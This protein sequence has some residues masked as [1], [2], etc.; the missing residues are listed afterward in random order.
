MALSFGMD[1]AMICKACKT[2]N[3]A[4][5]RFCGNCGTELDLA[6]PEA[7]APS[8]L[9]RER[10][11]RRRLVVLFADVVSSTEI[12]SR[13]D[14]E[15]WHELL[16]DYQTVVTTAVE[17]L[18]GYVAK[19]LGDGVLA[20]FGWPVGHE[21][22]GERAALAGRA[23]LDGV[24]RLNRRSGLRRMPKIEIR[25]GI[26]V[27]EVVVDPGGEVYGDVPSIAARVQ[28]EAPVDNVVVTDAVFRS[29]AG[30]L[31]TEALGTRVLRGVD[32]PLRLHRVLSARL[33]P[34][35]ATGAETPFVG[36]SAE[37]RSIVQAW[38][39][40]YAGTGRVVTVTGEAGIG[41][42]RLVREFRARTVGTPHLWLESAGSEIF[43]STPFY[44]VTRLLNRLVGSRDL[45]PS[46][47]KR[48]L[49][50]LLEAAGLDVAESLA[51][52]TE[53]LTGEPAE[54]DAAAALE[55]TARRAL[56]LKLL[57]AWIL[58]SA[59][60]RPTVLVVEDLHWVDPS[61]LEVLEALVDSPAAPLLVILTAR[62]EFRAPW[63]VHSHHSHII[64]G[65]LDRSDIREI[66]KGAA[67]A[68]AL[69]EYVVDSI[70]NRTSGI[71]LF[72]EELARLVETRGNGGS[73][74]AIPE[75]LASSLTARLD[76]LGP[77]RD[78]AQIGAVIGDE[79]DPALLAVVSNRTPEALAPLLD[80]M[81]ETGILA[82]RTAVAGRVLAFRH[83][84]FRDAAYGSLLR[85]R[86]RQLHERVADAIAADF[87]A[88]AREH[89]SLPRGE[90]PTG[91]PRAPIGKLFPS[92]KSC[93]SP[94]SATPRTSTSAT[95]WSAFCR[96]PRDIRRPRPRKPRRRRANCPKRSVT[97]SNRCRRRR[98]P[99]P[100]FRARGNMRRPARLP[101]ASSN[102]RAATAATSPWPV[103]AWCR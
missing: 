22:D 83:S 43:R 86:R 19:Y 79:F 96:S 58:Q 8:G 15:D 97:P 49:V 85:T 61:T 94:V 72:A 27:G 24:V 40:A 71:P 48:R 75:T 21:N 4:G 88:M 17:G 35:P 45:D 18:G 34:E 69:L 63:P 31:A 73:S 55:P 6:R 12:S 11:E 82:S 51:P 39:V 38:D 50:H 44:A 5:N 80:R 46:S 57:V 87:P 100:P 77:A 78:I 89:P 2:D 23:I 25:I 9:D 93:R 68:P 1:G 74:Q 36:R 37:L 70:A 60:L 103:P 90:P 56:W 10:G 47:R 98:P 52:L 33:V 13:L 84:L 91:K 20:Y 81:A 7:A 59:K 65:R 29:I 64:L 28:A 67:A 66:V 62:P 54:P 53:L 26:H 95:R 92:S 14:P 41:K 16:A 32:Q 30:R 42:S 76:Q 102:W 99:G 3:P 101:T